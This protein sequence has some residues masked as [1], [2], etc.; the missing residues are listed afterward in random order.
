MKKYLNVVLDLAEGSE[1]SDVQFKSTDN[2]NTFFFKVEN[3]S[4]E[5]P[6]EECYNVLN[7]LKLFIH[8]NESSTNNKKEE[9]KNE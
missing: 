9:S 4:V 3:L 6:I 7:E 2:P 5:L 8:A 1:I